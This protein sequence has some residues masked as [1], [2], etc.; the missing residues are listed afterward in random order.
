MPLTRAKKNRRTLYRKKTLYLREK[1]TILINKSV[2][3]RPL[4]P[5]R[6]ASSSLAFSR[7]ATRL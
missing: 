2:R 3:K 4:P 5:D 1:K 6:S 7:H